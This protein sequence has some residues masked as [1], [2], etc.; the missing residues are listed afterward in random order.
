LCG[1]VFL[2]LRCYWRRG[3]IKFIVWWHENLSHEGT[4]CLVTVSL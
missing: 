3:S 4:L 1:W 2:F